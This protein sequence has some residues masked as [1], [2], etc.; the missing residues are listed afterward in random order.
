MK[1]LNLLLVLFM[2]IYVSFNAAQ[3]ADNYKLHPWGDADSDASSLV[4]AGTFTDAQTAQKAIYHNEVPTSPWKFGSYE[5]ATQKF[6]IYTDATA[7]W[8][9]K[10]SQWGRLDGYCPIVW[11]GHSFVNNADFS[12]VIFYVAPADA[13]YKVSAGFQYQSDRNQSTA[14][15][16]LF[17][18]K[19]KDGLKVVD[20]NFGKNYTDHTVLNSDFYVNLHA[21]DTITFNQTCTLW[22]DPYCAWTK[23]QVMGNDNGLAFTA[24]EANLSGFYFDNYLVKTDFSF[25]N[26]KIADSESLIASTEQNSI[27]GTF[28]PFQIAK[29]QPVI[30]AAKNF[31]LNNPNATQLE[32]NAQLATLTNAYTVF[33]PTFIITVQPN[34]ANN[35]KLFGYGVPDSDAQLLVNEGTYS[36]AETAQKAIV[37]NEVA[38]PWKF[39]RYDFSTQKFLIY[40]DETGKWDGSQ[41]GS[42]NDDCPIVYDGHTFVFT[43]DFSPAIFFVA[44]KAGIYLVST[45]FKYQSTHG[46]DTSGSDFFQFKSNDGTPLVD[47]NYGGSYTQDNPSVLADFFVNMHVGDTIAFNQTATKWGDPFCQWVNL[48]VSGNEN[49]VA[50]TTEMATG[51]EIYFNNYP[52]IPNGINQTVNNTLKIFNVEKGIRVITDKA[53]LVSVYNVAGIAVKKIIVNSDE[54]ISLSQGAYIVKSGT[55]IR[56]VLVK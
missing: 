24:A 12:P 1:K 39:G 29:F 47:M 23:L 7:N 40:S 34:A 52:V 10:G 37:H 25:L 4:N 49:G 20:M 44:P 6:L 36:T 17:Q 26:A 51:S 41:W 33:L 22:G 8:D 2:L 9:A 18:F 21:G 46:S 11:E 19:A 32:I 35:Y 15:S 31:V 27:P 3:A 53:A 38:S 54:V 48:Q 13:I 30:D 28:P 42:L 43:A 14:G 45:N 55:T 5:F 50:Y 56:K 16:S